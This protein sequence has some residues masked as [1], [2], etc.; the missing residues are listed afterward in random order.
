MRLVP[1]NLDAAEKHALIIETTKALIVEHNSLEISTADLAKKSGLSKDDILQQFADPIDAIGAILQTYLDQTRAV[2]S[3]AF[4]S[5]DT[6]EDVENASSRTMDFFC[7][8]MSRDTLMRILWRDFKN[9]ASLAA[10]EQKDIQ[11]QSRI[12][13]DSISQKW[14]H[15]DYETIFNSAWLLDQTV[16]HTISVANDLPDEEAHKVYDEYK[17]LT[18]SHIRDFID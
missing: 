7:E 17:A 8:N 1:S 3:E 18:I 13:A 10:L 4:S 9:Y 12:I 5:C 15:I 16:S 11:I 6:R 14:P 2:V